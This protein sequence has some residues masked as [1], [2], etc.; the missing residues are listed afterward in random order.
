MCTMHM[1]IVTHNKIVQLIVSDDEIVGMYFFHKIF[2]SFIAFRVFGNLLKLIKCV[3][4]L[5]KR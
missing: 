3:V 4:C 5:L 2:A 1:F